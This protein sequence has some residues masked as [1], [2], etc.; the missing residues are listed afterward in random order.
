MK[1]YVFVPN[2][3]DKKKMSIRV[4]D[5]E[6]KG[7]VFTI[8][9]VVMTEDQEG[10]FIQTNIV[11][12][13]VVRKGKPTIRFD[14]NHFLNDTGTEIIDNIMKNMVSE[15]SLGKEKDDELDRIGN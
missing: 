14:R 11:Y 12:E 4:V 8:N 3:D 5:G 6:Y 7:T 1:E 9:E 10:P 2:L 15:F 13:I